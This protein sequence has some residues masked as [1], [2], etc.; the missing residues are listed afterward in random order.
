M[1]VEV[2]CGGTLDRVCSW[3]AGL[4]EAESLGPGPQAWVRIP[5]MAVTTWESAPSPHGF[6][7]L[8]GRRE[9]PPCRREGRR[10]EAKNLLVCLAQRRARWQSRPWGGGCF[11]W[12]GYTGLQACHCARP[13]PRL[14]SWPPGS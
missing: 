2:T 6:S 1:E 5:T 12:F 10:I 14:W 9:L 3:E 8:G 7:L 11:L 4:T 13:R